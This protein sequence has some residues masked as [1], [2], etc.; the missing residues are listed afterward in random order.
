[1]RLRSYVSVAWIASLLLV[2]SAPA[3]AK[4]STWLAYS[5]TQVYSSALRYLRVD[6]GLEVVERDSD[7]AYLLFRYDAPQNAEH[8][9]AFEIVEQEEG[10]RISVQLPKAP[11]YREAMLRDG[12]V[13]KIRGDYGQPPNK[14][15]PPEP[16]AD[17]D[18][19]DKDQE[20][21]TDDG[22]STA[23]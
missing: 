22:K 15:K 7:A 18:S 14:S 12:L 16:D 21:T 1:M 10:V 6:L 3:Q 5:R 2:P 4:S 20:K 8:L 11:N 13:K 9:G 19:E 23:S 17:S